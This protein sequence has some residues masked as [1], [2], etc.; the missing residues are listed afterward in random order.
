MNGPYKH[1]G[2]KECQNGW[3]S[4]LR[5]WFS[6]LYKDH[7]HNSPNLLTCS[8]L[9]GFSVSS[10]I[11]LPHM[12]PYKWLPFLCRQMYNQ[13]RLCSAIWNS[14]SFLFCS[15]SHQIF[16]R[17]ILKFSFERPQFKMYVVL[18]SFLVWNL[19]THT[20]PLKM[21]KVCGNLLQLDN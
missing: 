19:I 1:G 14:E 7:F 13:N 15:V 5:I 18:T 4:L 20:N 21:L 12:L 11:V 17:V 3:R 10:F 9:S 6:S 16:Y 2:L 8:F